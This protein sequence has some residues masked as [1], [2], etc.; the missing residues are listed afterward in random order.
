MNE[1]TEL[2]VM[3]YYTAEFEAANGDE[4]R[5]EIEQL[6]TIANLGYAKSN[7]NLTLWALNI[8]RL[9]DTFLEVDDQV[10]MLDNLVRLKGNYF[11]FNTLRPMI[12]FSPTIGDVTQLRQ[13]ADIAI[14]AVSD[15]KGG[16]CGVVSNLCA[17]YLYSFRDC[18][19]GVWLNFCPLR[20]PLHCALQAPTLNA[21]EDGNSLSW[22]SQGPSCRAPGRNILGH[23]IGHLLGC[24]HDNTA[25]SPNDCHPY[26]HG[27]GIP[28]TGKTTIMG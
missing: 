4:P 14:L 6:T 11:H 12:L 22:V 13:T 2:S 28:G 7:L 27:Y 25:I 20:N 10:T 19:L 16:A 26:A 24:K 5:L 23:E 21:A 8:D 1:P 15:A 3:W 17:V 18:T 9:P